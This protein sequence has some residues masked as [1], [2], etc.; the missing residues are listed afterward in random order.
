MCV[1]F[2]SACSPNESPREIPLAPE[3]APVLEEPPPSPPAPPPPAPVPEPTEYCD[4]EGWCWPYGALRFGSAVATQNSVA[5]GASDGV[6]TL[7]ADGRWQGGFTSAPESKLVGIAREHGAIQVVTCR[8]RR[9]E[10]RDWTG[11]GFAPPKATSGPRAAPKW[12]SRVGDWRIE[13]STLIHEDEQGEELRLKPSTVLGGRQCATQFKILGD[14]EAPF[15]VCRQHTAQSLHHVEGGRLVT[16]IEPW[17]TTWTNGGAAVHFGAGCEPCLVTAEGILVGRSEGW[18]VVRMSS[19]AAFPPGSDWE[20][21][22]TASIAR[23]G[24]QLSLQVGSRVWTRTDAWEPSTRA[25]PWATRISPF[26]WNGDLQ[27]YPT[28]DA[29]VVLGR[30]EEFRFR[31]WNSFL[32]SGASRAGFAQVHGVAA[33]DTLNV[34]AGPHSASAALAELAPDARCVRLL[35]ATSRLARSTWQAIEL[36]DGRRGWVNATYLRPDVACEPA[37][38]HDAP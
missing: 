7:W 18:E 19:D 11:E 14:A 9:C 3:T 33:D 1:S 21:P 16:L 38:A 28:P 8:G 27:A 29:L 15:V 10:Q 22:P 4:A 26:P 25:G 17:A 6:I 13:F 12:T 37:G 31:R 36:A 23:D 32:P 20:S 35:E 2:L 24:D 5:V 34:R 30:G